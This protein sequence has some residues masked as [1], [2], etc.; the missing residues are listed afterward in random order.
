MQTAPR[1]V[2][3]N[4]R[5]PITSTFSVAAPPPPNPMADPKRRQRYINRQT[6]RFF[7]VLFLIFTAQRFV[8]TPNILAAAVCSTA[9]DT[10]TVPLL[11]QAPTV[12]T[13]LSTNVDDATELNPA[14]NA[15]SITNLAYL[16]Q[17]NPP[18]VRLHFGFR[19]NVFALPEAQRGVWDFS[20]PDAAISHMRA[21]GTSFVLNV[22]SAPPW[23]FDNTGH[24][25]RQN[26]ALF[27]QYM[28]RLVGWYN[29]GGFTDESGTYHASGYQGWVHMWE[30][31]N[32][33]DSGGEIPSP[34]ANDSGTWMS[35][36]DY[37]L[38]YNDTVA[39]MRAVDPTIVTG[40]PALSGH[41]ESAFTDYV[42]GFLQNVT[43]P[44]GFISIHFYS[45]ASLHEP[46]AAVLARLSA[47]FQQ[48]IDG[49]RQV[50][51]HAKQR[52]PLW[53]DELGFNE[54]A[55]LPVDP[56]GTSP[57]SYTFAANAFMTA[58]THGVAQVDQFPFVG[59]TQS[60]LIDITNAQPFRTYWLYVML[61]RDF[62]PGSQILLYKQLA[63]GVSALVVMSPDRQKLDLL[64]SNPIAAHAS[65]VNGHGV[66]HG[67]CI[68]LVNEHQGVGLPFG[69]PATAFTFD[70]T[71][72]INDLPTSSNQWLVN[73]GQDHLIFQEQLAGYSATIIEL[74]L[75]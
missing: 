11:A 40:G 28:A 51:A 22:R 25:P 6:V 38:L 36:Q 52:P 5:K 19:G 65:D 9:Q 41:S 67:I 35:P 68:D 30:I 37:A 62:P 33:P 8:T 72:P 70:A 7:A 66:S 42:S 18:L 31:W 39:A 16:Q 2:A 24:L 3:R 45:T 53:V 48:Y 4:P 46:D 63:S 23:M 71:T 1:P 27:A 59:N 57:I 73:A 74:P 34:Y 50:I 64:L 58:I 61:A 54:S 21:Q 55:R 43:Q 75:N 10:L 49:V 12:A 14:A 44:V 60:G 32:E 56:R 13:Q 47:N 15:K 26:F 29:K 69:A 17:W 20:V